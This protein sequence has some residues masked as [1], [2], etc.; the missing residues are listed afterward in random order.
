VLLRADSGSPLG[1]PGRHE[2]DASYRPLQP[3]HDT[4]TREPLD[5]RS[6]SLRC[7]RPPDASPTE[8][9]F[10]RA[11]PNHLAAIR[12]RLG[13]RLTARLQLW[14][15]RARRL[16][17]LRPVG[18]EH[19]L[20]GRRHPGP[21]L[22]AELQIGERPLAPPVAPRSPPEIRLAPRNHDRFHRPLVKE[23]GFPGPERLSST[24]APRSAAF[25]VAPV[26]GNPP[27]I[28][29][30]CHRRSGFRRSFTLPSALAWEG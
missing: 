2:E 17:A 8:I 18:R 22:S 7:G 28:S 1:S 30:L 15:S 20:V 27:P 23:N 25:A 26:C 19:R 4:S 21:A 12:S 6:R 13:T 16:R 24:S 10:F 29:R 9:G 5:S 11:A 3:T 14:S